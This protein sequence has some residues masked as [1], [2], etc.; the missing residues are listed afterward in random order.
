MTAEEYIQH[1]EELEGDAC[2]IMCSGSI[3]KAGRDLLASMK[4]RLNAEI[5]A[6]PIKN[7]DT[8]VLTEKKYSFGY[9]DQLQTPP[10]VD[11]SMV[12]DYRLAEDGKDVVIG[13]ANNESARK[14]EELDN[15]LRNRFYAQPNE[16][17]TYASAVITMISEQI[18]STVKG[19]DA[20]TNIN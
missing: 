14:L 12:N 5:Q 19:T 6:K 15:A 17:D 16:T 3:L 1:L 4:Q 13:I 20:T 7:N 10:A 11:K 18:M 2:D 8:K 9:K